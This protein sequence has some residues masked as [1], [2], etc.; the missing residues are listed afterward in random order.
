MRLFGTPGTRLERRRFVDRA[1]QRYVHDGLEPVGISDEI[2]SSWRRARESYRIDPAL[3]RSDRIL[4]ADALAERCEQDATFALAAPILRDF[5]SPLRL[6][7]H[8]LAYFDRDG[9]ML[10][11][12][13]DRRVVEL[14][15]AI[16]F[17]PG[18]NWSEDAAGTNGPGTAL[19]AGKAIEVFAS[20]HFVAA[21]QP[22]SCAAAPVIGPGDTT[23]VGLVDITG[24]WELQRRQA[25]LVAKAI[26][27]AVHERLRAA[28]SIRDEV[29]KYEFRAAHEAGDA[30]VAVDARGQVIAA[31]G[32]AARR[33]MVEAGA[34]A[35]DIRLALARA[36]RSRLPGSGGP[37]RV[38]P[39]D[40]PV[41]IVSSV[42][43]E[44]SRVGTIVR[45]PAPAVAPPR[46]ARA[47]SRPSAPIDAAAKAIAAIRKLSRSIGIP[48]G[49]KELGVKE[50][51]LAT[52][53]ENAKRDACQL[54]NPRTATLQQVVEIFKAAM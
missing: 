35:P 52:M 15:E 7:G 6:I 50:A 44:G 43:Y 25:I 49:L 48:A 4:S 11:I 20:E 51:D 3:T 8:V 41:F 32:A 42:E 5:A 36:R 38:E 21:W 47:H 19:A 1:W 24:P 13:G 37:M 22:W 16:N 12:D 18:A 39:P 40:G 23:P 2:S 34:L 26:A 10:S 29:V 14:V 31:N 17:R 28:A 30:L 27:R 53:A 33:R 45:V 9:W 54:T 46:A